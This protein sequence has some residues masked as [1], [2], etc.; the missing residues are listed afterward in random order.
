[1]LAFAVDRAAPATIILISGD[2]DYAYAVS[3]LKLRKYQVILV[4]P[5]P[6][7]SLCL[8][9]QAS[10]VIDW[11]AAVLRTRTEAVG[12]VQA[13]RQPYP[14][15]D[16]NL[17]TKLM[18]ELQEPPLDDSDSTSHPHPTAS[19]STPSLRRISARD[20]LEPSGHSKNT[21]NFDSMEEFT[22]TRSTRTGSDLAPGG[23]P[24]PKTPSHSRRAS[25]STGSSRAII[26]QS[27][28]AVEQD[29]PAKSPPLSSARRS[30]PSDTTDLFGPAKRSLSVVPSLEAPELPFHDNGP[31]SSIMIRSPLEP[32]QWTGDIPVSG[33]PG[34]PSSNRLNSLA[35]PLDRKSTRLNSSHQCLSRMPSSA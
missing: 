33:H 32:A 34:V 26:A 9:S 20:L 19:Q 27:S 2:R 30:C 8:Q 7:S 28:P 21:G 29:I 13:I 18:R 10:L 5:S 12:S 25:V 15:V 16:A 14:D 24:N 1:M 3:T 17:V 4:V 35:S 23:L 22:H 11:G 31:P 6:Q